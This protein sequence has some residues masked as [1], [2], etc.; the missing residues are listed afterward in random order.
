MKC[1]DKSGECFFAPTPPLEALRTVLSMTATVRL[2]EPKGY[3][4]PKSEHR[5]QISTLDISRAYFN[6]HTDPDEP[7]VVELPT[8]DEDHT[9]K[10]G[11]LR[12]HMYGTRRAADGWQEEYSTTLVEKL[13]FV[14]G[15]C[16]PCFFHHP[17]RDLVTS[18][19][20]DD[21]TTRGPKSQ[22]DWLED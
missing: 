1:H 8:E 15:R 9:T 16:C 3:R 4:D 20:G 11:L 22:L 10:V 7:V 13:G 21:F 6:A 2:G 19:H 5:I 18:V 14:Q 12:R 17:V